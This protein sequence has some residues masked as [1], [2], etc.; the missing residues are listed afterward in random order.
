LSPDF[1]ITRSAR[2]VHEYRAVGER[3]VIELGELDPPF[4]L[5]FMGPFAARR[6]D[7][8]EAKTLR[9]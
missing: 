2:R 8:L 3:F 4:A 6:R 9:L 5:L 7:S 1:E